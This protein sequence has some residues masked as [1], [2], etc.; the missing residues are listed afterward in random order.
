MR[1][2]AVLAFAA[3]VLGSGLATASP[4]PLSAQSPRGRGPDEDAEEDRLVDDDIDAEDRLAMH[5]GA[6]PGTTDVHGESWISLVGLQ[7]ELL[8]GKN[9]VGAMVIVGLALDRL[10]GGPVHRIA[11]PP[12]PESKPAPARTPTMPPALARDCVAAALRTLGLGADDERIDAMV[13]RARSSALLPETRLRA[14]RLWDDANH[15]TTLSTTDGT[16]YYD[17]VGANLVLEVRLTW[18]LDRLV[19]AGDEPTL[20]RIRLERQDARSRV[21]TRTLDVLFAWQRARADVQEAPFE[22]REALEAELRLSQSRATL[23]VLT[24]GWFSEWVGTQTGQTRGPQQAIPTAT[25]GNET[26]GSEAGGSEA[27]ETGAAAEKPKG[28][29]ARSP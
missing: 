16:N 10:A 11:D 2:L 23:D 29:R 22:S 21:A 5:V 15:T 18:R 12:H 24:G 25:P 4:D 14:M 8:S 13:A 1:I 26:G 3:A 9:D 20:E 27:G 17:A 7:R 19:Y 6:P 28:A